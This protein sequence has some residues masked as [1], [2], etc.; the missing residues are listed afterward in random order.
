[1]E[2]NIK[3]KNFIT[4]DLPI[5]STLIYFGFQ[6]QEINKS[7]PKKVQFSFCESENLAKVINAY[8]SDT[9]EVN[10]RTFFDQ[11]KLLKTRIFTGQ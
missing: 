6:P 7:N 9:L 4:T 3:A 1:M 8:F 2:N 11:L 5:V 10:P